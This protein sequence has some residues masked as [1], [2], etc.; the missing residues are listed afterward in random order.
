MKYTHLL[1]DADNTLFDYDA[2][3][4][5]ALRKTFE[6]FELPFEPSYAQTYRQINGKIWQDF[7]AGKITQVVLRTRRF[8]LLLEAIGAQFDPHEFSVRYLRNLA[9]GTELIDGA[10]ELVAAL[11]GRYRMLIVTNGLKEVQ[12]RRLAQSA[13]SQYFPVMIIS[14]EVGASK[15][16]PAVFDAVFAR[17]GNPAKDKV[18]LIGDSLTSDI[19]GG[20]N[21]NID[22]CWFNRYG[23]PRDPKFNI[24]YEIAH[25]SELLAILD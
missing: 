13:I 3:E 14:E 5:N 24:Q 23:Q 12:K 18:L 4:A 7:E 1:F 11:D 2:A 6:Q 20:N 19:Q 8:A 10:A 16:D 9:D 22:V 15:P 21:Y 25:L 17:M